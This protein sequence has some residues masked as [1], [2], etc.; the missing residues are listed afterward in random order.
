MKKLVWWFRI[1]GAFYLLLGVGN[2]YGVFAAPASIITGTPLP[3][4]ANGVRIAADM[5]SAFAF[6]IFAIGTFLLWASRNPQK[7]VNVVWFAVW[8]QIFHG[9]LDD[10]F[11]I[12]RGYDATGYIIFTVIHLSIIVT[13]VMFARQA[14]A[15]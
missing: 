5:W 3:I 2:L 12:S 10:V 11:L 6:E 8:L 13:G 14:E 7:Y 1:V 15:K 9:V 4:D